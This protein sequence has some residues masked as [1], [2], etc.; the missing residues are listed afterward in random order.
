MYYEDVDFLVNLKFPN[1]N[2]KSKTHYKCDREQFCTSF[3]IE[4][5]INPNFDTIDKNLD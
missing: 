5:P 3:I 4:E 2:K 1:K